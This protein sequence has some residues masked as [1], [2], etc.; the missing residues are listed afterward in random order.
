M[1][2]IQ[3]LKTFCALKVEE[4]LSFGWTSAMAEDFGALSQMVYDNTADTHAE[5]LRRVVIAAAVERHEELLKCP[6]YCAVQRQYSELAIDVLESVVK[7]YQKKLADFAIDVDH[8]SVDANRTIPCERT[9]CYLK[10]SCKSHGVYK[11]DKDGL[12]TMVRW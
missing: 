3:E 10:L 12:V 2:V 8:V 6:G 1:L 4:F 5:E 9:G 11:K 7:L